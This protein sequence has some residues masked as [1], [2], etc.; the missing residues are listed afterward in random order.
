MLR[1]QLSDNGRGFGSYLLACARNRTVSRV[2]L[3]RFALTEWIGWWL[4]RRLI[5]PGRIGRRL[6][7]AELAGALASPWAYLRARRQARRIAASPAARPAHMR[8]LDVQPLKSP[9]P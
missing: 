7:A 6:V 3:L 2:A 9:I 1:R 5:R 8:E 4:L